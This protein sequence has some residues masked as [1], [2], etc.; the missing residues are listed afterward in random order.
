MALKWVW[1][2]QLFVR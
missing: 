2:E 1:F